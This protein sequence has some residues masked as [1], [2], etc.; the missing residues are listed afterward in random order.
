MPTTRQV[1]VGKA[2]PAAGGS[3]K[4]AIF[5]GKIRG[6]Q[7]FAGRSRGGSERKGSVSMDGRKLTWRKLNNADARPKNT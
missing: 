6:G 2:A 3:K 1:R 4:R 5:E 7:T